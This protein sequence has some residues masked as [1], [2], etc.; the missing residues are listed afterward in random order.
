MRNIKA[1]GQ[2]EHSFRITLHAKF[3]TNNNDNFVTHHL[4]SIWSAKARVETGNMAS[5]FHFCLA[6]CLELIENY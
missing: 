3:C 5:Y 2:L 1:A 6:Q 4:R